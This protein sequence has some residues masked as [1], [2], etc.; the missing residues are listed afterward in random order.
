MH[1]ETYETQFSGTLLSAAGGTATLAPSAVAWISEAIEE[2]GPKLSTPRGQ[3]AFYD[4]LR[5]IGR[6]PTK[7]RLRRMLRENGRD[8]ITAEDLEEMSE[9]LARISTDALRMDTFLC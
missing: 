7:T 5:R 1:E 2:R 9:Q 6:R 8:T 4:L 3:K